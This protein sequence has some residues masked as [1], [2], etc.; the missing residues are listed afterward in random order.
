LGVGLTLAKQLVEMDEGAHGRLRQQQASGAPES[1]ASRSVGDLLTDQP[2]ARR[3]ERG[4]HRELRPP[5][6]QVAD[7]E[8]G[9][10]HARQREQHQDG[11]GDGEQR[12]ADGPRQ[13]VAHAV[14]RQAGLE[15]CPGSPRKAG[16]RRVGNGVQGAA[17]LCRRD[18]R[19][20]AADKAQVV[21]H[22]LDRDS[23]AD[24]RSGR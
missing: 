6:G 5:L 20:Q 4:A 15:R 13:V 22:S 9:H 17:R 10:V 1:A 8:A 19:P 24:S 21:P 2:Q 11:A 12:W 3:A 7:Q 18:A 14:H 16:E 23:C